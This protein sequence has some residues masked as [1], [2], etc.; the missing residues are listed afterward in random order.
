MILFTPVDL[1]RRC[2]LN[3]TEETADEAT[4]SLEGFL[5]DLPGTRADL[6]AEVEVCMSFLILFICCPP[7]L[8]IIKVLKFAACINKNAKFLR[9]FRSYAGRE[10]S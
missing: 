5:E 9:F 10:K 2:A 8:N 7:P 4:D 1:F 3:M 6:P